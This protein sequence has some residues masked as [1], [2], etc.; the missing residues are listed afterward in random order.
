MTKKPASAM[1]RIVIAGAGGFAALLIREL[2]RT[3]HA[4][5]VLSRESH[6]ELEAYDCQVAVV[7]YHNADV[8]KFSLQGVDLVISTI[9]GT[10]Q[11]N[12]IDAARL[13][14]VR[15]FVPSEFEGPLGNRPPH[16]NDPFDNGSS[17]ALGQLKLWSSSNRYPMKYTVF[18]CGLFYERF[19]PGG[20]PSY[21]MGTCCPLPNPGEYLVDFEN[22]TAE[23]PATGPQGNQIQI[24]LTSAEDVA[25]FVAGAL[26]L[27]INSWPSE[28]RMRGA[29][30]TPQRIAQFC[31]EAA[32]IKF[33]VINRPYAEV[34]AWLEHY[35]QNN[36]EQRYLAMYHLIQTANGRY[37]MDRV[38]L[39][40]LL[41]IEPMGFKNW[42]AQVWGS[43]Q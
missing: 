42:L 9:S 18:S 10:E 6:P 25:R 13:A 24:T 17:T 35:R 38:N 20:L 3:G 31:G 4:V 39:N 5:L 40:D 28:F 37:S 36:D 33:N 41:S 2:S 22:G 19:A 7:D 11:L 26:E 21:N 16:Q 29:R 32:Q 43:A 27:G 34:A 14:G 23:L 30:V 8:L 1:M 12:L 15:V